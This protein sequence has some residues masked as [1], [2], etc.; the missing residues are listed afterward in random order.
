MLFIKTGIITRNGNEIRIFK[1][2]FE[3]NSYPDL[4]KYPDYIDL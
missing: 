1:S 4:P 3:S 2:G